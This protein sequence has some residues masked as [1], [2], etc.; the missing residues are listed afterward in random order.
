MDA[1]TYPDA[2]VGD[3][4]SRVT[5]PVKVNVSTERDLTA[6]YEIQYTPTFVFLDDTRKETY[7]AV[8][9]RSPEE[10]IPVVLIGAAQAYLADGNRSACRT[11]LDIVVSEYPESDVI[12]EARALMDSC[13]T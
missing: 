8:G 1:V 10:F 7:R 9:F 3:I 6:R 12:N 2:K 4:I 11:A 13:D 5:I